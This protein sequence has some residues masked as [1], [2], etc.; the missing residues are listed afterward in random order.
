MQDGWSVIAEK[1]QSHCGDLQSLMKLTY[2][3]LQLHSE[4]S[5]M[6]DGG[7]DGDDAGGRNNNNETFSQAPVH[8]KARLLFVDSST[9]SSSDDDP[10]DSTKTMMLEELLPLIAAGF[11]SYV[12]GKLKGIVSDGSLLVRYKWNRL[13]CSFSNFSIFSLIP[14]RRIGRWVHHRRVMPVV[15]PSPSAPR[16][17]YQGCNTF[18]GYCC[19]KNSV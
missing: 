11:R 5:S 3:L 8:K 7:S 2:Q 1:I 6:V 4:D 17:E 9:S 10:K 14:I 13:S 15:V 16:I 18:P 12:S 19:S